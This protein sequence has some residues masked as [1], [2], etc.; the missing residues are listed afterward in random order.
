[1]IKIVSTA[2][3]LLF[4]GG[5]F[6]DGNRV[7]DLR[8]TNSLQDPH[9]DSID[10]LMA[11]AIEAWSAGRYAE[12]YETATRICQLQPGNIRYQLLRGDIGFAA[13][14]IDE[15]IAAYDAAIQIDPEVG[16]Q[17]WQRGLALYYA[18]RFAD[19]LKQ[20]ETHQTVN[21]QDVENAVWHLLC[22]A[23]LSDVEQARKE[24]IPITADSRVPMAEIYEMF[25]GRMTSEDVLQAAR[26]T[27]DRMPENSDEH[28]LRLYYAWLYIG[29]HQEMLGETRAA[30]ES[31]KKAEAQN[32]MDKTRFMG[33]VARVH[34]E[35]R[36]AA[37]EKK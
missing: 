14:K 20:F 13:G 18:D 35:L 19:G 31:L 16:P 9:T 8:T 10:E 3:I 30:L 28:K 36:S 21:S 11:K 5:V 15:S 2:W 4:L 37:S 32:A 12:A 26:K 6:V 1:V 25:A 17:L 29:L 34:R 33:Q 24:L 27:S 7:A 23:R 22:A